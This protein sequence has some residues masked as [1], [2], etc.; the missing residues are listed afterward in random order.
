MC[1]GDNDV[2]ERYNH[3]P[4]EYTSAVDTAEIGTVDGQ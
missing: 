3:A 4:W 2:I 1:G